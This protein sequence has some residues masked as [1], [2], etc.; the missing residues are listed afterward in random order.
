M[1]NDDLIQFNPILANT[2]ADVE[3]ADSNPNFNKE[4]LRELVAGAIKTGMPPDKIYAVIKTGRI[5]TFENMTFLS[6][7]EIDE[8]QD[9]AREYDEL[10]NPNSQGTGKS[11]AISRKFKLEIEV[12]V[13]DEEYA[14]EVARKMYAEGSGASEPIDDTSEEERFI[15]PEEYIKDIEAALIELVHIN[16]LLEQAGIEVTELSAGR[17]EA[18]EIE[19]A[20]EN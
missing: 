5:L 6:N 2:L 9:A 11:N 16:P 13:K 7:D 10:A 8:W 20:D 4:I 1:N 15:S 12:T 17:I 19:K 18:K 14:I 3:A